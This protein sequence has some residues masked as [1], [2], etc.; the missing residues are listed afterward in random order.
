MKGLSKESKILCT[1]IAIAILLFA[2]GL[3]SKDPGV[4]GNLIIIAVFIILVPQ[5]LVRYRKFREIRNM[6]SRFPAFLRDLTES[7]TA[8]LPLHKALIST[9]KVHYGPLSK[10]IEKMVNQLSWNVPLDNVL[11]QFSERIKSSKRMYLAVKIIR[12]SYFS[13]GDIKSTLNYLVEN[14]ITL[15][16]A[17]KEKSSML[18]QYVVL[19]YAITILFL[20]IIVFINKLMIPMFEMSQQITESG[21]SN[22]CDSCRG[23]ECS[24]CGLFQ[25]VA[26]TIFNIDE[27]SI[28]SYYVSLFFFLS[29]VQSFFAGLVAGQISEGSVTAGLKHSL[30][31]VGIVFGV[32][33]ILVRIGLMGG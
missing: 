17:T 13:G 20:I 9:S 15:S 3:I 10:E 14:Q 25:G 8:G 33:R 12:E 2:L 21:L 5:F 23:F 31:L 19:M 32:F 11:E 28:A 24:I 7:L 26:K 1:S 29:I 30:I 18:N 6:E 27:T 16:E 22:P 4:L